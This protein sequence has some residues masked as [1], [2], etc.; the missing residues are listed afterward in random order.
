MGMAAIV[1][2]NSAVFLERTTM[3]SYEE[4]SVSIFRPSLSHTNL[5]RNA[6]ESKEVELEQTD[7][8]LV[9]LVHRCG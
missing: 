2:P 3:R 5:H 1:R 8:D 6:N 9:E 7:H 4:H